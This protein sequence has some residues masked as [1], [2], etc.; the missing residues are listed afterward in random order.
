MTR[1]SAVAAPAAFA[2][3]AA[4][5]FGLLPGPAAASVTGTATTGQASAGQ[6]PLGWWGPGGGYAPGVSFPQASEHTSAT[7]HTGQLHKAVLPDAFAVAPHGITA[8]Q[9][10]RLGKLRHVHG[11]IA[12]DGGEV[13]VNGHTVS[14]IGADPAQFRSWTPPQTASLKGVWSALAHG[15]FVATAAIAKQLRLHTGKNYQISAASQPRASFGGQADLGLPRVD[16]LV[17]P[18]LSRKL[19]LVHQAGVLISAPGISTAKLDAMVRGV[20]GSHASLVPLTET[21]AVQQQ[22]LAPNG[23]ATAGQPDNYLTLFQDSAKLYCPGMS[24][25][26]LAAIGQIESGDGQNDGPSSA[27]ALGPMQFEPGTWRIWGMDAFGQTGPPDINNAYDA[28]ASAAAYLCAAGAG[29][30][31]T[32][33]RA[34]YS[35]NHAQWYVNEVLAL[36]REYGQEY[37]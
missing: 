1:A 31:A 32:L 33:S 29:N 16:A 15:G 35:Y 9:L 28:V 2:A 22:M 10:T 12:V 30:P 4:T 8:A 21:Q 14:M 13:R 11:V 34:I 36:A 19:G 7:G 17:G 27:G 20:L 5:V 6:M 26:V 18:Q 25:T 23:Q 24:W 3:M 37:H